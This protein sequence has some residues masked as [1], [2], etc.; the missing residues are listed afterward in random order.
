[1]SGPDEDQ[2]DQDGGD[3][4]PHFRPGVEPGITYVA[5]DIARKVR[6][7]PLP[8]FKYFDK[9]SWSSSSGGSRT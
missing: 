7:K 9:G 1:M 4:L 6:G 2:G 5:R 8:P 3:P